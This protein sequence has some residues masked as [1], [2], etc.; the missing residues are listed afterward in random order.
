MIDQDTVQKILDSAEIVDVV[1]DFVSLKKRGVNY[2]GLCPFHNEKT[3]SF[4]VSPSKGIYKCFGCGKG[5]NAA[6][7]V[8]E[9]EQ[10]SYPEALKYLA[11][12]YNIEVHDREL[13]ADEVRQKNER[14]SLLILTSFAQKHFTR[15]LHNQDEGIAIGLSYFKE[16][17]FK[18]DVVK[19]FQLGY[20]LQKRD[21]FTEYALSKGYKLDF[22]VKT[23]LTIKKETYQFD[24]FFGRVMFPIHSL[25]GKVIGFGGRTMKSDKKTAKYLNSPESLIYHKSNV[26]YGLYFAKRDIVRKDKCY[27]VEGYTDVLALHQS[28]IENVVA[29][30]GTSLTQR[31]IQ[32]VKRFTA[33]LTVIYDGDKAGI[34]ASLRG[35]DLI[36]EEEMNVK[37][38]PLPDGEDPDSF[39]KKM[40]P[41]ELK[42]YI[43]DKE[44]D[45][46]KFK[47]HL[48]FQETQN[49]PVERARL[50]SSIV[51]SITIIP[52]NI[53]RAEYFKECSTILQVGEDVL[54]AEASKIKSQRDAQNKKRQYREKQTQ[55]QPEK[56][57][58]NAPEN[59][60]ATI[61]EPQE[62]EI[63]RLLLNYG[64]LPLILDEIPHTPPHQK[65]QEHN[66]VAEFIIAELHDDE[67]E[68]SHPLYRKVFE[69][70]EKAFNEDKNTEPTFDEKHF[71]Q[72]QDTKICK[73]AA[74][75]MTNPYQL[76]KIW[77]KNENY[78]RQENEKLKY[79]IP[80]TLNAYKEKK[81]KQLLKLTDDEL[82]KAQENNDEEKMVELIQQ[83]MMLN[84][85]KKAI[86]VHL[87]DRVFF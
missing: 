86:S 60:F 73:L 33:N 53:I 27:M 3:P 36:L 57:Q 22:L 35:I 62:R 15:Q 5:G 39:S 8:M 49:D 28:G 31:Q 12:K 70:F 81:I 9:H 72:H 66:T 26:L 54:Y 32:M 65:P 11:K 67:L 69:E 13:T 20:C 14:E 71:T 18:H 79:I 64:T 48:L 52:N 34:K 80:D 17:G 42:D 75:L 58:Q 55:T 87:G 41:E 85:L 82:K 24:R 7:F 78:I 61:C 37:V 2:L 4:V 29:S 76:S 23:G 77:S 1:Q 40:S 84:D 46:I 56:T 59:T 38:V 51:R 83:K 50:I 63:I 16:R 19:K 43:K 74:E 30:S 10:L 25:S 44:I 6:N 47:T 45:F 68:L 21:A